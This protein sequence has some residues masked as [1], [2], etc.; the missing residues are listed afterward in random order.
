MVAAGHYVTFLKALDDTA[1][2]LFERLPK[3]VRHAVRKGEARGLELSVGRG[4]RELGAFMLCYR[5][6][7]DLLGSPPFGE[8][9]FA[10][11]LGAFGERVMIVVA[12]AGG[13]P[14]GADFVVTSRRIAMPIFGGLTR[15][16]R[17]LSANYCITWR[18]MEES[19]NRG[20]G[21]YDLGRSTPGTGSASDTRVPS[22]GDP[23]R[24]TTAG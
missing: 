15:E 3:R 20:L 7:M 5:E 6:N 16:G 24:R 12:S 14:V 2:R 18:S 21:V 19:V 22:Q 13:V 9:F 8:E 17:E 23:P 11:L 10:A 1:P 4:P